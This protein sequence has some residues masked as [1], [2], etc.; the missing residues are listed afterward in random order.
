MAR[1][2][3]MNGIMFVY[4]AIVPILRIIDPKIYLRLTKELWLVSVPLLISIAMF[5]QRVIND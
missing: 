1:Y 2:F 4:L 5:L 3:F